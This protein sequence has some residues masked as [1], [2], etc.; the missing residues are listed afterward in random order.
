MSD[1]LFTV[2]LTYCRNPGCYFDMSDILAN[3]EENAK[4]LA[5]HYASDIVSAGEYV[6]SIKATNPIIDLPAE[7]NHVS[8]N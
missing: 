1:A 5:L 6:P 7:E 4:Q 2:R 3:S 8:Q